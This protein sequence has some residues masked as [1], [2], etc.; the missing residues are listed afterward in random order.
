MKI[1]VIGAG[2]SG[3]FL[4]YIL[5][6]EKNFKITVF[7]KNI[8]AGRKL[9]TTGNG[10]CNI[11][12]E[13]ISYKNFHGTNAEFV[14]Y[15]IDRFDYQ[16]CKK[17]FNELGIEFY[18]G[19]KNRVYPLTLSASTVVDLLYDECLRNGVD[20][21]FDNFIENI[22]YK[23]DKFLINKET[24]DKAVISTGSL[25]MPKLGSNGSGYEIAKRFGHD[26]IEPFASLVQ[27]VC[28]DKEV[29]I[30]NGLKI[31]GEV[32]KQKDDILFT[33]YGISGSAVLDI[34]RD[35]SYSLQ[36]EKNVKVTVDTMPELSKEKIVDIL[37][38]KAKNY[39]NR[40]LVLLLDGLINKKLAKYILLKTDIL[41]SKKT[42]SELNRK[43]IQK[44][45]HMAK[46]LSFNIVSTKGFDSCEVCAGGIDTCKVNTK[47]ME[48]KLQKGLYFTGEVVDIDGDCGG[49]NLHWAWASAYLAA[50]SLKGQNL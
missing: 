41:N 48:S 25:A 23:D 39:P 19:K 12:N 50:N 49:Y 24:F 22:E 36:Y 15:A 33:K 31:N 47:T 20:F 7:E 34:S 21:R 28:D 3:L 27:L 16:K 45:A 2:A 10:R 6:K 30:L 14:K 13:N 1:S 44:I 11:T 5:S 42:A 46:N 4:S 43:D 18:T 9:L 26:I 29:E 8:K 37:L 32:Q 38:R 35:I 40:D 17:I